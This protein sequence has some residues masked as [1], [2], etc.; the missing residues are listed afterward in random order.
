MTGNPTTVVMHEAFT[1]GEIDRRLFGSFVEHMGR[2][3]YTGIYEPNHPSAD[4]RGFRGDVLTLVKELG[5]TMVRYPGGNFVSA[6]NWEDGVGPASERPVRLDLAWRSTETNEVGLNEFAEWS[7][8]AGVELM[9]AVNLG[10]RGVD[11]ARNLVEYCNHPGGTYWSDLRRRHGVQAP[12]NVKVWCLG[13]E[14]DAPWQIGHKTPME[15]GRIAVEAAKAMRRVDPTI[16]LVACGSSNSRMPTFGAWEA[17]VLEQTYDQVDYISLHNYYEDVDDRDLNSFLASSDSMDDFIDSV[18]ATADFVKG[19]LHSPK[20]IQ[21]SFDEWNIW[22]Q[23]EFHRGDTEREAWRKAPDLAEDI[24]SAAEA[25]VLGTLL[26]SLLNH[27]DRVRMAC[28][29]QLVNVIAPI[30]TEPSGRAWRQSTFY[31]FADVAGR[32]GTR[33]LRLS[34]TSPQHDTDRY[35]RVSSVVA[36]ATIDDTTGEIVLF[37]VNRSPTDPTQLDLSLSGTLA[38]Y[39]VTDH[40]VLQ[41][42]DPYAVNTADDP[43]KVEP[44]QEPVTGVVTLSPLSWNVVTMQKN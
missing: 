4:S 12:H 25:V 21:L 22:H 35:G 11:A 39:H 24:Y 10:T 36:A 20:T 7:K 3:V 38:G 31:P 29:A 28:L 14:M 6:Y 9:L 18:V 23:T 26:I 2:T 34:V 19:K 33:S 40:R 8:S 44:R 32:A 41:N 27:S 16:E 37:A 1:I 5:P 17:T 13:N 42:D 43:Y 15:Y 30:T